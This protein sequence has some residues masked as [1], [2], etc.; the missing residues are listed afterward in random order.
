MRKEIRQGGASLV[1]LLW[2]FNLKRK[3]SE[4]GG[5]VGRSAHTLPP[6][7]LQC[8]HL[9]PN[10]MLLRHTWH[11]CDS[12]DLVEN[13]EGREEGLNE[14][15]GP[16]GGSHAHHS[17]VRYGQ[18]D[19]SAGGLGGAPVGVCGGDQ[20]QT[21][22]PALTHAGATGTHGPVWTGWTGSGARVRASAMT[23]A[24]GPPDRSRS[25]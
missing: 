16:G 3:K 14:G 21:L 22:A 6:S 8:L 9:T 2:H 20:S 15:A 7:Y 25:R 23:A 17:P 1:H 13:L 10:I 11:V 5:G 19:V 18:A 24:P 12:H 4:G